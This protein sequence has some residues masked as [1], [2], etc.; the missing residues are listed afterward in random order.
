M[1]H[2]GRQR[3]SASALRPLLAGVLLL[4]LAASATGLSSASFVGASANHGTELAASQDWVAPNVT[5]ADPGA[6]IRGTLQLSAAA[7]DPY[8]SGVASVRIERSAAGAA[9]WTTICADTTAPYACPLDTTTL[10][11]DYYDFRA[12]ATDNAGLSA[13]DTVSDVQADNRAPTATMVDP[14]SPLSGVVT[15][16]AEASDADSGVAAVT[17]QRSPAGKASWSDICTVTAAPYSC[18]FDTRT[19]A[20]GLYDLRAVATDTAGNASVSSTVGSRRIDNTVSSISLEDPGGYLRGSVTLNAN[21]SSTSGIASVTIQRSPAGRASWSD[22]CRVTTVPYSCAWDTTLVPDGSYDL[23]ALMVT[24][25]G[26]ALSSATVAARQVD[27]TQVRGVDVQALN[28]VGG[29]AGRIESGDTVALTYSEQ[30]SPV[31]LV[32]GWTGSAPVAIYVRL[33]DGNLLGTGN[34]GDTLQ[35]SSDSSG[36]R[37]LGLG[38]VNLHGDFVKNNKTSVFAA[39]L[40]AATQLAGGAGAT[41]VTVTIGSLAS[42]GALRTS[43]LAAQM[44]WTPS[45]AATDL[46]GNACSAAPVLESG[47]L[48]KDL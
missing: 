5:L 30:M 37:P 17:I 19:V 12:V 1:S 8:G 47:A 20:E 48:D 24:G 3:L 35:F 9:S 29:T 43:A 14:G 31:S 26:V 6:A 34:T 27:N 23:R 44:A 40:S 28:K 7:S 22:I 11:S 36:S 38:S 41:V 2:R 25:Q 13:S 32:P 4:A 42:G 45:T 16:I 21:A 46:S 39:T 33:R 15:L 10:S 18:R